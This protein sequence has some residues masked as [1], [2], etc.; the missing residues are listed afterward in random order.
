MQLQM[1]QE[2]TAFE[3]E[4]P[5]NPVCLWVF[6]AEKSDDW[7]VELESADKATVIRTFKCGEGKDTICV[8]QTKQN[9]L[10]FGNLVAEILGLP[11]KECDSK[12]L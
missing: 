8:R 4:I 6:K 10:W 11:L 2:E 5:K 3:G 7:F 1:V 9:A 12:G